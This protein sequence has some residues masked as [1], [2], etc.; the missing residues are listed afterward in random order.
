MSAT[1]KAKRVALVV[2]IIGLVSLAV[3]ATVGAFG[4]SSVCTRCGAIR[5]TTEWQIPLTSINVFQ[6]SS[7]HATLVSAALVKGGIITKH[8]HLW[9][10]SQGGGNGIRCALGEGRHIRPVVESEGVATVI[11]ASQK[12]SELQF[13]DR[14][15]H[16]MFDPKTSEAVR[17]LGMN[18]PTN[19]F[20]DASVFRLW[21]TQE[22]ESFEETV[23]MHQKR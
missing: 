1:P 16:A 22:T 9:L 11:A 3:C 10:F 5:E 12:F 17:R 7:E 2:A 14:L 4:F 15:L 21:M 8:E 18:A 13:R 6:H 23:A 19:G 20:S